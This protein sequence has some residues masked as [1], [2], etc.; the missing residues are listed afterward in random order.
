MATDFKLSAKART[1][2]GKGASRRLRRLVGEIPA[3]VYGGTK[4]PQMLNVSHKDLSKALEDESF[5]SHVIT[6]DIE[7][8]GAESV[9]LKALQRHPAKPQLLHADFLRVDATHSITLRVPLHFLNADKCVGVRLGGGTISHAISELEVKCLPKDLP[10]FIEVDL[11]DVKVG[12]ILHISDVKLP[13]GVESV[14]L[15]HGADH[16][17]PVV[18]VLAPR[19]GADEETKE[20][21]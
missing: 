18:S 14:Q 3:I 5:Y 8:V 15:S 4:A 21:A 19:G 20:E 6:L 1:D 12:D 11:A 7:G 2:V 13:K 10:E 17:L 9:V 16:D